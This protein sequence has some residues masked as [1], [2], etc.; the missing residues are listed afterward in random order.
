MNIPRKRVHLIGRVLD[1]YPHCDL[2]HFAP[3]E[4]GSILLC[5]HVKR[6]PTRTECLGTFWIDTGPRPCIATFKNSQRAKQRHAQ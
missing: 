4:R 6:Y 5:P 2:G 1:R 3:F